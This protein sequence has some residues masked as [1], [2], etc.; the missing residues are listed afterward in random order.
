MSI[1]KRT[2]DFKHMSKAEMI[3]QQAR[4]ISWLVNRHAADGGTVS[5]PVT[6]LER[7]D[8]IEIRLSGDVMTVTVGDEVG[9]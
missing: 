5:I 7:Q 4:V 6:D 8:G 3:R 9:R 2:G 1:D